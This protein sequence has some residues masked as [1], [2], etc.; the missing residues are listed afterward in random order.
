MDS[1]TAHSDGDVVRWLTNDTVTSA[2][3][4][5]F[6]LS[7]VSGSSE[8][9]FPS[10]GRRSSPGLSAGWRRIMW[11]DGMHESEFA[12]V[13]YDVRSDPN[14]SIVPP[15]KS[16]MVP[17]KCAGEILERD[18][19]LGR[20]H[21]VYGEMRAKGLTDYVAW[22]LYHTLGK[23]HM[24]TF[25][26]TWSGGFDDALIAGLLKLLGSYSQSNLGHSRRVSRLSSS[27]TAFSCASEW[28]S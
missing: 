11:A 6:L 14:T 8:P 25:A 3:L 20:K 2:S 21:A 12:R 19:S 27:A 24:V 17:P 15:T 16:M 22:P 9:T 4:I 5:V 10:S 1:I 26:T 18:S 28:S 7:C 23:R 13:D